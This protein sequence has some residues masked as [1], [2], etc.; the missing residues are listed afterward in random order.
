MVVPIV[1]GAGI[2][3][4]ITWG[5]DVFDE[6]TFNQIMK[7]GIALGILVIIYIGYKI[8]RVW[9]DAKDKT[10][11]VYDEAK[12]TLTEGWEWILAGTNTG[13]DVLEDKYNWVTTVTPKEFLPDVDNAFSKITPGSLKETYG[14]DADEDISLLQKIYWGPTAVITGTRDKTVYEVKDIYRDITT[15]PEQL[16]NRFDEDVAKT[17]RII[18]ELK[19]W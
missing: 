9:V 10:E 16:K 15:V 19:F 5:K 12:E 3:A 1:A 2:L 11:D 4:F 6:K 8:Y 7:A 13:K 18:G 14:P 17:K